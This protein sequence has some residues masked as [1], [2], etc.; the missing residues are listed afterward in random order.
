MI[1]GFSLLEK[2]ATNKERKDN[3]LCAL[4]IRGISVSLS[5]FVYIDT[6][7]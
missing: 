7:I 6:Y 4:G 5:S 1:S 2:E 3:E